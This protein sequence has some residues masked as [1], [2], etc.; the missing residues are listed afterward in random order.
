MSAKEFIDKYSFSRFS[1]ITNKTLA[2][3]MV[4]EIPGLTAFLNIKAATPELFHN[5]IKNNPHM[6]N[7]VPKQFATSDLFKLAMENPKLDNNSRIY[8][9]QYFSDMPNDEDDKLVK[10]RFPDLLT[11]I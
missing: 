1:E 5:L 6:W 2:Y 7:D 11:K 9:I 3:K 8:F 4:N 10:K